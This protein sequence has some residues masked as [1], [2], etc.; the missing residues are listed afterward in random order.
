MP[1]ERGLK[2]CIV[3]D[4]YGFIL[5]HRVTQNETDDQIAVPIIEETIRRFSDFKSCSFDKD[6]HSPKNQEDFGK[7][8]KYMAR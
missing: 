1:Q 4:Q 6:F 3:K 8:D 5:H 7:K 2:V